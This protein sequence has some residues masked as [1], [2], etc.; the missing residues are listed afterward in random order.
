MCTE[1]RNTKAASIN[2]WMF[3]CLSSH[4]MTEMTYAIVFDRS[5]VVLTLDVEIMSFLIL[6]RA[7][8]FVVLF[9]VPMIW[10]LLLLSVLLLLFLSSLVALKFCA[11]SGADV[12]CSCFGTFV[13]FF[14]TSSGA[15]LLVSF[16]T[17]CLFGAA[18]PFQSCPTSCSSFRWRIELGRWTAIP[19]FVSSEERN[20]GVVLLGIALGGTW[21][22]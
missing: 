12:L 6:L 13:V 18:I 16:S 7:V 9:L 2:P 20:C 10:L 1:C 11:I 19:S 8:V 4:L 14:S 22:R 3:V 17:L 15:F 21:W 5:P